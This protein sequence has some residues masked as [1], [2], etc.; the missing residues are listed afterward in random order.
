MAGPHPRCRPH[1]DVFDRRIPP[2]SQR[3]RQSDRAPLRA[4]DPCGPANHAT[5]FATAPLAEV[6]AAMKQAA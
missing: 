2:R 3:S 6:L 5:D 4:L 1:A